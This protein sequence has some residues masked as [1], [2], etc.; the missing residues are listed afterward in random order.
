MLAAEPVPVVRERHVAVDH[1][2]LDERPEQ[3]ERPADDREDLQVALRLLPRW[4]GGNDEYS[5]G[6]GTRGGPQARAR[7]AYVHLRDEEVGNLLMEECNTGCY[8]AD[9]SLPLHFFDDIAQIT[10]VCEHLS[11]GVEHGGA[12]DIDVNVLDAEEA[13]SLRDCGIVRGSVVMWLCA[14]ADD[15]R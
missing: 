1:A 12:I 7:D 14:I 2:A 8:L 4:T 3:H 9:A 13:G 11:G 10:P 6:L 5:R 15:E